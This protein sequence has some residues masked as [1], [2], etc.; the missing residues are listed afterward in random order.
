MSDE[1]KFDGRRN[2]GQD[3]EIERR[4]DEH[5]AKFDIA[6]REI[7]RNF[8]I[9]TRRIFLKKFLAHYE[10]FQRVV[11]LPGD[12]VELGVYRGASLMSWANFLEIRNMGDRHKRVWG[13]DNFEGFG[14][15]EGKDGRDD[16]K[17][18]KQPGGF[19]SGVFLDQLEDA[20]SIFDDDRFIP[21]KPRIK[22]VKGNIEESVPRWVEENPGVRISLL[23]FDAD[24]YRPTKVALEC[25]WPLVVPGGV[26]LFDEYGIPPWEGE[27]KAVDEFFVGQ[28]VQLKRFD[29]TPN[30][31]AYIVKA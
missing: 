8:Q 20:I 15:M 22:L 31:G 12:I 19:A 10:L 26:V 28:P 17:V 18:G 16:P 24:L 14:Q 7:W 11:D 1:R 21:Y 25:L 13:F 30:P 29:W 5:F 6:P 9:Y 4:L 2:F 27:S 3:D 23:H